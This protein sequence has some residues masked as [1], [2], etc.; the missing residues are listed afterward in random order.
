M[1]VTDLSIYQGDTHSWTVTVLAED[2]APADI[3]GSTAKAQIRRSVADTD[4]TVAAELATSVASPVVTMSLSSAQTRPLTGRYVWD[5]QLT[6]GA[7]AITTIM[8][9]AA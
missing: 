6:D 9:G 2:G 7:G 4:P 3:T 1:T 8:A 5:L